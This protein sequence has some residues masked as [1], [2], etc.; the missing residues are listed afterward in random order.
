MT[1]PYSGLRILDVTGIAGAYG[2]RLFASLGGE[3]IKLEPAGGSPVRQLG[4]FLE[5]APNNEG[6]LWWAYLAMGSKS[7]VADPI[8]NLR[9]VNLANLVFLQRRFESLLHHL[10]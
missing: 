2:T 8:S 9:R 3:V 10:V 1:Q 7:V 4:P 5:N 6:S